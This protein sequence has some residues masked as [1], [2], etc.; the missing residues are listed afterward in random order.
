[1]VIEKHIATENVWII[2]CEN[3]C[4]SITAVFRVCGVTIFDP[5]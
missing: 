2:K 4:M 5:F 3:S 1:M